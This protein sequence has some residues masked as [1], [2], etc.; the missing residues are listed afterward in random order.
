MS[1]GSDALDR[2]LDGDSEEDNPM[3]FNA[4]PTQLRMLV[5]PVD[6]ANSKPHDMVGWWLEGRAE[7]AQPVDSANLA[8]IPRA[9]RAARSRWPRLRRTGKVQS[10]AAPMGTPTA[11]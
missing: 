6:L 7:L 11:V 9:V 2:F 8:S 5:Q 4:P 10:D 1:L 3:I